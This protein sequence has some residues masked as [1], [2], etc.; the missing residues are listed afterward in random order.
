LTIVNRGGLW[1]DAKAMLRV[2]RI[3]RVALRWRLDEITPAAVFFTPLKWFRT[4]ASAAA[5]CSR[6]ARLR[7]ALEELGPI[8]VKFGQILSTRRDLMPADIADELALLQDRVKPFPGAIALAAIETALGAPIAELFGS[9]DATPLAS[10]S[11]AQVHPATMKD[12]REVVIKVLR[13]GIEQQIERDLGVLRLLAALADRRLADSE[14]IRPKEVVAEISRALRDEIDLLREGANGSLLRRNF[15][16]STEL[17]VPEMHFSHSKQRALTMERVYGVPLNDL[18]T[19]RA[20]GVNFERLAE[21]CVRLFYTQVFRDNF[22][23]ADVHPGNL[24]ISRDNPSDPTIIALDFGIMGQLSALDQRYLAENFA[25]MFSNDYR[26]IAEL[27][28]EAGWMPAH[29]RVDELEGAVRTICEPYFSRPLSEVSLGEVLMKLFAL[30]HRYEL[31]VQPQLLLLQK[32]LLNI[33]GIARTLWPQLDIWGAAKPILSEIM[34]ERYGVRSALKDIRTRL[35]SWVQNSP[36]MPRLLYE[37]LKLATSGKTHMDMSSADI[38]KLTQASYGMQRTVV[39]AI[40]GV[41]LITAAALLYAFDTRLHS[42]L[43]GL[44]TPALSLGLAGIAALF[45]AWPRRV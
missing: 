37:Y 20:I 2:L 30:A 44:P 14:R 41:A 36:E 35:P 10:A 39:L 31:I 17:K 4:D 21:R 9:V 27:H 38:A 40:S 22:F 13:P 1:Q 32:T 34:A 5:H 43:F 26:R 7:L 42:Q 18:D 25:A 45:A 6:G 28:L 15:A 11:I 12:G 24:L 8:F 29:V 23:H 33:E 16:G 19:L 3:A